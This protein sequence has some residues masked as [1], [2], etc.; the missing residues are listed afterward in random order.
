[1]TV[2]AICPYCGHEK[3]VDPIAECCGEV[4]VAW[5][6]AEDEN[7]PEFDTKEEAQA[8]EAAAE[9]LADIMRK[10]DKE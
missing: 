1:M 8:W 5:V 4:H 7:S 10:R 3:Q 9:G 6:V 2:I